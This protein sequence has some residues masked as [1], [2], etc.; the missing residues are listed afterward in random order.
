MSKKIKIDVMIPV[1]LFI[2]KEIFLQLE[3]TKNWIVEVS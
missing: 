1:T 2:S 3:R